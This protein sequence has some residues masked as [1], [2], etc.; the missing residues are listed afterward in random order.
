LGKTWKYVTELEKLMSNPDYKASQIYHFTG[1]KP[2][3]AANAA[4]LV[5]AFTVPTHLI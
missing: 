3:K 2:E 4:F 5:C 1:I